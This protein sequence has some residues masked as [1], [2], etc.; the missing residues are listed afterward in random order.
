MNNYSTISLIKD[1]SYHK[2][3]FL[4]VLIFR[5]EK[6][7]FHSKRN[8]NNDIFFRNVLAV[9]FI[10]SKTKGIELFLELFEYFA[11]LLE[12]P[13]EIFRV[14]SQSSSKLWKIRIN[15]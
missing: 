4:V 13:E 11:C 8:E 9:T 12:K 5:K 3:D 15:L 2:V 14:S 7:I 6:Y 10:K 1:L